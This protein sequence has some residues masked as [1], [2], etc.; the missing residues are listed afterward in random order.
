MQ[1]EALHLL[2]FL[3]AIALQPELAPAFYPGRTLMIPF[4]EI[5]GKEHAL[6]AFV[7][8]HFDQPIFLRPEHLILEIEPEGGPSARVFPLTA[9]PITDAEAKVSR[10]APEAD[11][12]DALKDLL[13]SK[14]G[15]GE[16]FRLGARASAV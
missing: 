6:A 13:L 14:L 12:G 7:G 3:G 1:G 16:F 8:L 9:Y 10:E 5:F 4:G 15:K 11:E 2:S